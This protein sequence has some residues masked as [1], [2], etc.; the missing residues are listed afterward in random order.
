MNRIQ[1]V[2]NGFYESFNNNEYGEGE[3][4]ERVN[5][6]QLKLEFEEL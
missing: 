1:D 6:M 3:E 5:K 2:V 4:E